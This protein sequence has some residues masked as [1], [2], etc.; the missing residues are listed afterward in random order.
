MRSLSPKVLVEVCVDSAASAVAAQRGGASRVELCSS[1]SEGGITPS[2][3][4]MEITRAAI[5]IPIQ[6]M[7]RPRAGDFC[8]DEDEFR[9]MRN[10]IELAKK[11][12]ADGIVVGILDQD[13]SIDVR[14]TRQLVDLSRPLAV[15]F[16]RGFDMTLDLLR[17]LEDVCQTG[18]DRILTSGGEQTAAEGSTAIGQLVQRAAGRIVIMAGS[19]I[20]AE[21]APSLVE[22]TGVKEI[23]V[24][25]R[26]A[27]PS[28]MQ[29]R[30]PR[31]TLG[32]VEGR[33]YQRFAVLEQNVARLCR[34]V[35][36][37]S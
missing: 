16:H 27:V 9:V 10:D 11:I 23:H 1:L 3:G 13:G 14:R 32:R 19:G 34:A 36:D 4:L 18:A 35:A 29:H 33:E 21:N 25:L 6:V 5:S 20:N 31:I 28:P 24:G 17:A 22:R 2:A 30:N 7:I 12:G 26:S 15:T 8:Y 37:P